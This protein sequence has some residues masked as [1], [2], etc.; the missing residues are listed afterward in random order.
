MNKQLKTQNIKNYLKL[1]LLL[2]PINGSFGIIVLWSPL[3]LFLE[4]CF[5]RHLLIILSSSFFFHVSCCS[6]PREPV[7]NCSHCRPTNGD[8]SSCLWCQKVQH[9]KFL[10]IY[11]VRLFFVHRW[12]WDH[13]DMFDWLQLLPHLDKS[14]HQCFSMIYTNTQTN[15]ICFEYFLTFN[16]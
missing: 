12:V 8:T 16:I 10:T 7:W 13:Y 14:Y 6:F 3:E 5:K 2:C 1:F 15:T 4:Y 9:Y 11:C